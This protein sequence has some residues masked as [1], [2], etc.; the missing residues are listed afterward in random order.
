MSPML[1][2]VFMILKLFYFISQ[3]GFFIGIVQTV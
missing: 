2:I 3:C 1:G